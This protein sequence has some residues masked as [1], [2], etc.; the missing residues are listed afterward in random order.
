V[1]LAGIIHALNKVQQDLSPTRL[2]PVQDP[3]PKDIAIVTH[4]QT[5]LGKTKKNRPY[6]NQIEIET[7]EYKIEA[8]APEEKGLRYFIRLLYQGIIQGKYSN[9]TRMLIWL[10]H[11]CQLI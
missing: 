9:S 10:I 3:G 8:I 4:R 6:S 2:D 1:C 5:K 7:L 11:P